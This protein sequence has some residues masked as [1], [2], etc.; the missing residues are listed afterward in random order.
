MKIVILFLEGEIAAA[1]EFLLSIDDNLA[2][3]VLD[4]IVE[5]FFGE[6]DTWT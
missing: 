4:S 2:A 1:L 5:V 6:D 3:E